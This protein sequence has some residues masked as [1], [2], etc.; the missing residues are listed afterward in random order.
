MRDAI[1][2]IPRSLGWLKE[3][4][5]G[6]EWLRQLPA[7]VKACADQWSL[8]LEPPYNG[9]SVSIV[10]PVML[11]SGSPAV[12]KVQFPHSESEHEAAALRSW[13]GHG[14][15]RLFAHDPARHALLMERCEPGDPLS[16][17]DADEALEVLMELLPGLWINAG[18]PFQSLRQECGGWAE[19]LPVSWERAK[20]PFEKELLEAALEALDR[21]RGTQGEQILIHQDLHGQNVLRSRRE[22]WLVIDP[23]PL[24]GE[25]EF[26]LAPIVRAREF[27]HSREGV[28]NRLDRLAGGLGLDRERARLWTLA[29]TLAWGFQADRV[30]A[31]HVD[32]ARWLWQA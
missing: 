4:A 9:S 1:F 26:T 10:F 16:A 12:L 11:A 15:V 23:K 13:N 22:P 25:R 20:R 21:L 28:V 17:I 6:R 5:G 30:L 18:K 2:E 29:Q 31:R 8:Q 3:F 32:I 27:G 24:A 19:Q 7:S 14:A